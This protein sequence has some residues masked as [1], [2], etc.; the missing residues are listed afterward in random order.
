MKEF[1][2]LVLAIMINSIVVA[3]APTTSRLQQCEMTCW[4]LLT[5]VVPVPEPS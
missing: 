4:L 2:V 1:V 3:L 5:G